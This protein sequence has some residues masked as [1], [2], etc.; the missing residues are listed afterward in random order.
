MTL[1]M[2]IPNKGRL[3]ERAVELLIKSGLDLGEGWGRRLY[4]NV[5]N[6]DIEVMFVRAQDIPGFVAGGAIDIGITG[7][8]Q[9]AESGMDAECL[10]NLEFGHC[11]LSVAVPE[12]S[13]IKSVNDL[14]DGCRVATSFPNLTKKFFASK[15]KKIELVNVSGAAEIM[16]YMGVS[17]IIV[18]LVSSGSTLKTNRL[19]AIEDILESQAIIIGNKK[20]VKSKKDAVAGIVRSIESVI[21]AENKKYLMAD[22]P[23][24]K[25]AEVQK[26]FPGVAGPT[27]MNIAGRDDMVAMHVV[28]DKKEV[29]DSVN[30]LKKMGAKG[31]LTLPIDRLVP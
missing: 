4:V 1:K 15:K 8:D 5:L 17:D 31:I 21:V 25:L 11:R 7:M 12:S 20:A 19:V 30:T 18:D 23:K 26:L 9:L 16:P 28:I 2:A 14:K 29:Y 13:G 6:Q 10:L 22:I 3:N 27:V 24:T